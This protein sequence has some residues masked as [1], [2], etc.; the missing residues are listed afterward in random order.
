MFVDCSS[1]LRTTGNMC[2][3]SVWIKLDTYL[4]NLACRVWNAC[5][6][7][8]SAFRRSF[9]LRWNSL[10][11][12]CHLLRNQS[13][14]KWRKCSTYSKNLRNTNNQN[15][16]TLSAF[17]SERLRYE[18]YLG[19]NTCKKRYARKKRLCIRPRRMNGIR[20]ADRLSSD[21]FTS[22]TASSLFLRSRSSE[23]FMVNL[24][25]RVASRR[26]T[27]GSSGDGC[28]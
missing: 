16:S 20:P 6:K 4:C 8:T 13:S 17:H 24:C 3:F 11:Y 18:R 21:N 12:K 1:R 25:N 5:L 15:W 23:R 2:V 26:I 9:G 27:E 14:I 28:W 22:W 19:K 7:C 10:W